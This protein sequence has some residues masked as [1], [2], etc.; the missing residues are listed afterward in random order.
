MSDELSITLAAYDQALVVR[1][2]GAL[3]LEGAAVLKRALQHADSDAPTIVIDLSEVTFIDST[4]VSVLIA[5]QQHLSPTRTLRLRNPTDVTRR[6]L[7]F[8][9]LEQTF[10]IDDELTPL[11]RPVVVWRSERWA[12]AVPHASREGESPE[13]DAEPCELSEDAAAVVGLVSTAMPFAGGPADQVERWLKALSRNGDA[14]F[15]LGAAGVADQTAGDP[16]PESNAAPSSALPPEADPVDAITAYANRAV[17]SRGETT[18][19]S[20]DL[21]EAVRDLYGDVFED[22]LRRHSAQ[23]EGALERLSQ[24]LVSH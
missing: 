14:G 3:D 8:T 7:H 11:G 21:L 20:T 22:V 19:R 9:G 2:S 16:Q 18:T 6:L 1:P 4:A 12:H 24:L 13:P 17:R 10:Q 5:F 23:P 15:V